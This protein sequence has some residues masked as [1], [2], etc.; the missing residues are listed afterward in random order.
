MCHYLGVGCQ[1]AFREIIGCQWQL[2]MPLIFQPILGH[3]IFQVRGSILIF[4]FFSMRPFTSTPP[5]H[6]LHLLGVAVEVEG[7]CAEKHKN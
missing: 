4:A 7:T 1:D 5:I 3:Y 6:L 2:E